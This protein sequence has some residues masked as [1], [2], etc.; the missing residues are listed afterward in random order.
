[1]KP[2]TVLNIWLVT[3]WLVM[4]LWDGGIPTASLAFLFGFLVVW[5]RLPLRVRSRFD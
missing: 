1:M 4:E 2:S 3:V 5:R